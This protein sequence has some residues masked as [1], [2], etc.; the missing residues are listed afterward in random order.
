VRFAIKIKCQAHN[1]VVLPAG[2]LLHFMPVREYEGF[3]ELDFADTW[4]PVSNVDAGEHR[5]SVTIFV[6]ED[7]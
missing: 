5:Y 3:H 1:K 7:E 4:C 2:D 6:E